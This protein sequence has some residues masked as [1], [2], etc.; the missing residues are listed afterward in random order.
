MWNINKSYILENNRI[1]KKENAFYDIIKIYQGGIFS[2][3]EK[4]ST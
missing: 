1:L 2:M 4:D 3:E